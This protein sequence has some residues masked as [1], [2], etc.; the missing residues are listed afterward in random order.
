MSDPNWDKKLPKHIQKSFAGSI[1]LRK[2]ATKLS[3]KVGHMLS[4]EWYNIK[5]R[6]RNPKR[7]IPTKTG[8]GGFSWTMVGR[9]ALLP[10]RGKF[11]SGT[12]PQKIK[13]F[14]AQRIKKKN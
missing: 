3:G 2:A 6:L 5:G 14:P 4:S 13:H 10:W 8:F 7:F 1:A 9:K 11:V 12:N